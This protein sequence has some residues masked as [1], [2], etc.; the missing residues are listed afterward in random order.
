MENAAIIILHAYQLVL[1][2]EHLLGAPKHGQTQKS[3]SADLFEVARTG[4]Q[5]K[6]FLVKNVD[7][8]WTRT[9]FD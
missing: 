9:F 2:L 7:T 1:G 4:C 6:G 3:R 5:G 8:S